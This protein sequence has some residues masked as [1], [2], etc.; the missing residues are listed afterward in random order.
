MHSPTSTTD[1]WGAASEDEPLHER[2]A[3]F[4]PPETVETLASLADRLGSESADT[5][6]SVNDSLDRLNHSLLLAC[7][8]ALAVAQVA[9]QATASLLAGPSNA[10][11]IAIVGSVGAVLIITIVTRGY[12]RRLSLAYVVAAPALHLDFD[13][14]ATYRR[15]PQITTGATLLQ[16]FLNAPEDTLLRRLVGVDDSLRWFNWAGFGLAV[17]SLAVGLAMAVTTVP[18][19]VVSLTLA[20]GI[21]YGV[22]LAAVV[23]LFYK[24]TFRAS[25]FQ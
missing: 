18:A 5:Q 3:D 14:D 8:V 21:L 12:V 4:L 1:G 9:L 25:R 19:V 16:R 11:N 22:T 20:A 6:R 7:I 15:E 17:G 2:H 10:T 24:T 23:G 13:P